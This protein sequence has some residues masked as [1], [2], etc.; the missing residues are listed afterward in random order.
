MHLFYE[1]LNNHNIAHKGNACSI[2]NS[3]QQSMCTFTNILPHFYCVGTFIM[4]SFINCHF[5]AP[6]HSQASLSCLF[7]PLL[8]TFTLT[9]IILMLSLIVSLS[10]SF[11][12]FKYRL[13]VFLFSNLSLLLFSLLHVSH[14]YISTKSVLAHTSALHGCISHW[15]MC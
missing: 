2:L 10:R 13:H 3:Y 9:R 7:L 4:V 1:S 8:L 14:L 5:C 11:T 15:N 6:L 12:F